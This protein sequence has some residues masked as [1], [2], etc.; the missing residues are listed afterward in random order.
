MEYY[1]VLIPSGN[2]TT[3]SS[4]Y[5]LAISGFL[6]SFENERVTIVRNTETS[7]AAAIVEGYAKFNYLGNQWIAVWT[8]SGGVRAS[9]KND[10][11]TTALY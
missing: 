8:Q 4:T 11:I 6:T 7:S 3:V 2:Y 9:I 1:I 5:G 10:Q